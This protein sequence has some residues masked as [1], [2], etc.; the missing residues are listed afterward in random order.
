MSSNTFVQTTQMHVD[1]SVIDLGIGQPQFSLL[2]L[3]AIRRAAPFP[4]PP[5][6]AELRMPITY[7][8]ER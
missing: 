1:P 4:R 2:P 8:L 5:V 3:E 6:R 7:Y